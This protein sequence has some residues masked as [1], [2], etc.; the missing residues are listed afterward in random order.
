MAN[1][2][3]LVVEDEPIVGLE[4]RETLEKLG[5]TV[6]PVVDSGDAVLESTLRHSPDLVLMDIRLKSFIDG[7]DAAHRLKMMRNIPVIFLTAQAGDEIRFRAER[8]RPESYLVK[9]VEEEILHAC[10]QKALANSAANRP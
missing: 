3:I 9:P 2:K 7:I 5:Y 8:V 10:I 4:L 6:P 1:Q